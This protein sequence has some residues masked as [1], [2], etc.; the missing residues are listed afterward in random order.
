VGAKGTRT[1][2]HEARGPLVLDAGALI[3]FE[4][5]QTS[6]RAT[7]ARVAAAGLPIL[8]PATVLAQV[9]RGGSRSASL[10]RLLTGVL[11]DPLD[12]RRAKEV[13]ERLGERDRADIADAHVVCCALEQGAVL[14]TSDPDDMASLAAPDEHLILVP[15]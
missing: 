6:V 10:A 9:W 8:V 13:G 11:G 2:T 15:V 14:I 4:R 12:E 3:A 5:G 1:G 7:V